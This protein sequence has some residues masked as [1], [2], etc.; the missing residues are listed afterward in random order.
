MRV[1]WKRI[2]NLG[3]IGI[4]IDDVL[5][6]TDRRHAMRPGGD[7]QIARA[8]PKGDDVSISISG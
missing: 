3:R 4:E 8:L 2:R 5:R 7:K 1:R 6:G